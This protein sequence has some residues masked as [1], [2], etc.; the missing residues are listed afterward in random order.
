MAGMLL[1]SAS[2]DRMCLRYER[3]KT[4]R[5]TAAILAMV[6]ASAGA[7]ATEPENIITIKLPS[8]HGP[9]ALQPDYSA[10]AENKNSVDADYAAVVATAIPEAFASDV[11]VRAIMLVP[12][13]GSEAV[14]GLKEDVGRFHIFAAFSKRW[15]WQYSEEGRA[16]AAEYH[17]R[18]G[19]AALRE[20]EITRCTVPVD[21]AL[22]GKIEK[23]WDL[24][25]H[26]TENTYATPPVDDS[27]IHFAVKMGE[28]IRTG[29]TWGSY[30]EPNVRS[31]L[32]VAA[33]MQDYCTSK[34]RR[35]LTELRSELDALLMRLQ[36]SKP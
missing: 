26:R 33:M 28:T 2:R 17:E 29:Q 36:A 5:W 31:F 23:A 30:P 10:F 27:E 24:M 35:H 12:M 25:L 34:K 1:T 11:R 18:L 6:L 20:V 8:L 21:A 3:G 4:M 22:A 15:L 32:I 19:P 16:Q 9:D 7:Y 13:P 14:V